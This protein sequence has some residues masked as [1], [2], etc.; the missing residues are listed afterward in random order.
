MFGGGSSGFGSSTTGTA[1]GGFGQTSTATGS[2]LFGT[3]G[4]TAAKPF[5]FG[6]A[7]PA[8]TSTPFGQSTTGTSAFGGGGGGL[9]GSTPQQQTNTGFG[10]TQQPAASSNPFGGFGAPAQ[11]TGGGLFGSTA[12]KPAGGLFGSTP[13]AAPSGGLFGSTP[14]QSTGTN[15]F[16]ASSTTPASGGLFGAKPA[17]G[18]FGSTTQ[19]QPST[20]GLFGGGAFGGGQ[21][22]Q[23]QQQQSGGLFGSTQQKP[24]GLFGGSTQQQGTSSLFGGSASQPQSG[25][26]GGSTQQQQ[27]QPQNSLFGGSSIYGTPQQQ[28]L[29]TSI[30]DAG[31]YG[32]ASL[33][34]DLSNNNLHNPGP[35]A[36]PL[37]GLRDRPKRAAAIPIARLNSTS[38]PRFSTPPRKG[39]GFSYSTYASPS[40][41][42]STAST[43]GTFSSSTIGSGLSSFSRAL[44]KSVSTSGLRNSYSA[45]EGI[46]APGAFSAGSNVRAFGST[47][48]VKRLQINRSLRSDLFSPP[49]NQNTRTPTTAPAS[50]T[51]TKRVSFDSSTAGG[52]NG[53]GNNVEQSRE[54]VDPSPQELGLLRP[55]PQTNGDNSNSKSAPVESQVKGNELAIVPEE[56]AESVGP[57]P[58]SAQKD[59]TPQQ[60]WTSPT[61]KDIQAMSHADRKKVEGFTV[62]RVGVGQVKFVP[63]I[64]MTS[65]PIDEIVGKLVQ[66][67]IRNCTVYPDKTV[68]PK[69]GSGLNVPAVISLDNSWPRARGNKGPM[70]L[71]KHINGLKKVP[72]T[73]F[74]SYEQSTGIWSFRVEHF[75]TYAFPSDDEFDGEEESEWGQSTMSL[76]PDTPAPQV[77]TPSMENEQSFVS[78][79]QYS[80]TESDPEDTFQFRKKKALPGAFEEA[81]AY[82][83]DEI[84]GEYAEQ[85]EESFLDD[86]SVGSE[87][88]DGT[89]P[90]NQDA[91]FDDESVSIMDQDMAGAY[92]YTDN[93][94]EQYNDS[95]DGLEDMPETPGALMRARMR[96]SRGADT[97]TQHFFA[98]DDWTTALQKTV[99]PKK[100]DRALLKTL[101]DVTADAGKYDSPQPVVRRNVPDTRGFA[102]SIDLMN[103]LFGANKSPA[104]K[105]N[106]PVRGKGFEV[107]FPSP[108]CT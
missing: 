99:S 48:S 84:E 57:P 27:Q 104:K 95:Q 60:Y 28:S 43:P 45:S 4:S 66:L 61:I 15:P 31:A 19:T 92:S 82:I 51:V 75:T 71:Q 34:A 86:R 11:Q 36:T 8:A 40:S 78:N 24:G 29:S 77:S 21:Q 97:P 88:E 85:R 47:G 89:E 18:L 65:L 23:G 14:Q 9:F 67:D 62:G 35:I 69:V 41:A 73:T 107:G 94:A 17:G 59:K 37:S 55:R 3:A 108:Y 81:D 74:V 106:A 76:P 30:G 52:V 38:S 13:A 5:S 64:D 53:S 93:T 80:R 7:Q 72:D 96:A 79:S 2:S 58:L 100:Q 44:T 39:Y 1:T 42:S 25:L 101:I 20:G 32:S 102:N 56:N 83:D 90:I 33:F 68:K 63:P 10:Q 98:T 70:K 54:S 91:T 87:S 50:K 103:S 16:G 6:T 12:A 49:P 105:A 26:F 46:L 22:A